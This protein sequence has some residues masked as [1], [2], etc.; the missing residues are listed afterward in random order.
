[1]KRIAIVLIMLLLA[2][3]A[4]AQTVHDMRTDLVPELTPVQVQNLIVTG[5][6]SNGVFVSS[7][8]HGEYDSIWVYMGSGA[9]SYP[10]S[11]DVI[12]V[13]GV[14]KIYN[15]LYEID[16]SA[17]SWIAQGTAA[18]P[19]PIVVPASVLGDPATAAPYMCSLI[20]IPDMLY[21]TSEAGYGEW[22]AE[23]GAGEQVMF[24]NFWADF[25]VDDVLGEF[26]P[27]AC[28]LSA[29]GCLNY[30]YGNYKMCAFED[31]LPACPVATDEASFGSVKS[32]FR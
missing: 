17:G 2:V 4:Q 5:F 18:L 32:L 14:F 10:A 22:Y 23:T 28:F 31:G 21:S 1:M 12:A 30:S 26:L 29:T 19:A 25:P 16:T 20:T 11:G 27:G 8:P 15:G 3:G 13:E 24:D 6:Y 9:P 7:V